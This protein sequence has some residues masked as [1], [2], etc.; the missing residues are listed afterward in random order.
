MARELW[1]PIPS[2][3]HHRDVADGAG[4]PGR[5]PTR[6]GG[7]RTPRKLQ[8]RQPR[9]ELFPLASSKS[10]CQRLAPPSPQVSAV[11]KNLNTRPAVASAVSSLFSFTYIRLRLAKGLAREILPVKQRDESVSGIARKP[12]DDRLRSKAHTRVTVTERQISNTG[13][14][15][16]NFHRFSPI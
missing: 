6:L 4:Q 11:G 9:S 2:K 7:T 14:A 1:R 12:P 5:L 15:R 10:F 8:P 16:Q 13:D 3:R